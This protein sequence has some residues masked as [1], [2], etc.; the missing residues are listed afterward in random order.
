M[1]DIERFVDS[2][3][4]QL[5]VAQ[6][7]RKWTELTVRCFVCGDSKNQNHGH[8]NIRL[9]D[10][11][12]LVWRCV[13]CTASGVV[14]TSFIRNLNCHND[15]IIKFAHRNSINV[16]KK[17]KALTG[18]SYNGDSFRKIHIPI[19]KTKRSLRKLAYINSRLGINI[20][21]EEA[22]EV[23]KIVLDLREVFEANDFMKMTEKKFIMSMIA[24]DGLGFISRDNSI[25]NFRDTSD[26]WD[27]RYF[28]YNVYSKDL[29]YSSSIYSISREVDLLEVTPSVY[30]A[31]GVFDIISVFSNILKSPKSGIFMGVTGKSF[32]AGVYELYKLGFLSQNLNIYSDDDVDTGF[33]KWVK[34][35]NPILS[36]SRINLFY[37][38]KKKD[39]GYSLKD[40]EIRKSII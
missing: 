23:Y 33:Y 11:S 18:S 7:N 19:S 25:I 3:Q 34:R 17:T 39:F 13:K 4:E 12:S 9:T 1:N 24:D 26:S 10:P 14:N 8:L 31:E 16:N 22:A 32:L 37:N 20:T 40:I 30:M 36:R 15:F 2:M 21:P 5:R 28:N 29:P 35:D 38:S 6:I 27:K